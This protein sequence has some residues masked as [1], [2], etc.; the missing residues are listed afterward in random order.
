MLNAISFRWYLAPVTYCHGQQQGH[1]SG[2]TATG[3]KKIFHVHTSDASLVQF[4]VV[5]GIY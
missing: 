5:L 2:A 4:V 3:Q 1:V